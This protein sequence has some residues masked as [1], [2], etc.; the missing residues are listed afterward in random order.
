MIYLC[1]VYWPCSGMNSQPPKSILSDYYHL[2]FT[3]YEGETSIADALISLA[4]VAGAMH[5]PERAAKLYGAFRPYLAKMSMSYSPFDLAVF[6]KYIHAARQELGEASFEA[7]AQEASR[8][9]SDEAM[10]YIL[11]DESVPHSVTSSG[12]T[13]L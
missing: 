3:I 12:Q 11:E 2:A 8:M 9:S 4:A 10:A 13:N 1:W 7:L 6:E 5:Q